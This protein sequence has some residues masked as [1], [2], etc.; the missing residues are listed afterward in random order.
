MP[1][2]VTD[3]Y[4]RMCAV[5]N[6]SALWGYSEYTGKHSSQVPEEMAHHSDHEEA[7]RALRHRHRSRF[8]ATHAAHPQPMLVLVQQVALSTTDTLN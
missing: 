8:L 2:V 1:G 7:V 4:I 3:T 5:P 6:Q